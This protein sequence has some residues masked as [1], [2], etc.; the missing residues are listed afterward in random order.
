MSGV[1][2]VA[3]TAVSLA[4]GKGAG[5]WQRVVLDELGDHPRWSA[6]AWCPQ[7]ARPLVLSLHTI[8]ADGSVS[9]SVVHPPTQPGCDWH[10]TLTLTG[11][12][13][14]PAPPPRTPETCAQC[15]KR[16]RA[17]GGWGT[18]A[19]SGLACAECLAGVKNPKP[20]R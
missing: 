17:I 5:T 20:E 18:W 2:L 11:W 7:C 12:A 13:A 6:V 16:S 4:E 19:G 10:P 15:G 3:G 8:A 14:L 1:A 9:P